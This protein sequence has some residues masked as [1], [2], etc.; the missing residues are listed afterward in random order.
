MDKIQFNNSK[1]LKL[2]NAL[3]KKIVEDDFTNF[4]KTIELMNNYIKSKG[5]M[6]VGPLIQYTTIKYDENTNPTVVISLIR[7]SNNFINH[8]ESPYSM[9]SIIRAKDCMYVRYTGEES[10]LKFA[11]DKINLVAFEE[12]I[13]LKGDSY[14]VFINQIEDIVTA[15]VFMERAEDE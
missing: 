15:D 14:T 13:E 4:A 1:T 11:Y 6:P 3:I 8:V 12:G 10:K 2:T 7:Q 5:Y 9:Q